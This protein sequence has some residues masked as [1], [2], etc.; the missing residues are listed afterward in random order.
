MREIM[1]RHC[2][3][4]GVPPSNLKK[5]KSGY[6]EMKYSGIDRVD[7]SLGYCTANVVACCA[8]CNYAKRDMGVKEFADW[9]RRIGSMA[10]QW[11]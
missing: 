8:V 11:G 10:E 6:A 1:A 7:S 4:C 5:S 3:Y 2:H 9:A